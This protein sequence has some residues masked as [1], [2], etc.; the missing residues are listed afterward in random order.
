ME[1]ASAQGALV[2]TMLEWAEVSEKVEGGRRNGEELC[3]E[4]GTGGAF[5][6][7]YLD[8]GAGRTQAESEGSDVAPV[9]RIR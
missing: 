5:V 1:A 6:E 7:G 2:H 8:V 3:T 4:T 9:L